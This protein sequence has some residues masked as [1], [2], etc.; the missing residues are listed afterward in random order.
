MLNPNPEVGG[1]NSHKEQN[2]YLLQEPQET[3]GRNPFWQE[4]L[5]Q[6]KRPVSVAAR[7]G[8]ALA[9]LMTGAQLLDKAGVVSADSLLPQV[10][11]ADWVFDNDPLEV[12]PQWLIYNKTNITAAVDLTDAVGRVIGKVAAVDNEE[13]I[14]DPTNAPTTTTIYHS[15]CDAVSEVCQPYEPIMEV[16]NTEKV[17]AMIG[18][19]YQGNEVDVWGERNIG[20]GDTK[21]SRCSLVERLCRDIPWLFGDA[22]LPNNLFRIDGQTYLGNNSRFEGTVGQFLVRSGAN[23]SISIQAVTEAVQGV[24]LPGAK[25]LIVEMGVVSGTIKLMSVASERG[26]DTATINY[27]DATATDINNSLAKEF[28]WA[29]G[30]TKYSDSTGKHFLAVDQ[31]SQSIKGGDIDQD[32]KPTG[33]NYEI[34]YEIFSP[35]GG[36]A[37]LWAGVDNRD[38]VH[39]WFSGRDLI[40]D[41]TNTFIGHFKKGDNPNTDPK[42][43]FRYSLGP[44]DR[45]VYGAYQKE[46]KPKIVKGLPVFEFTVFGT[47][48]TGNFEWNYGGRERFAINPDFSPPANPK[49]SYP[50]NGLEKPLPVTPVTRK[51]I[52]LPILFKQFAGGW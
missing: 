24:N 47:A 7:S 35:G 22:G 39:I 11:S 51:F 20:N 28:W 50:N 9:V 40:N 31:D 21:G 12:S 18:V 32:G 1:G 42:A 16:P 6:I 26:I 8:L 15:V 29:T 38:T 37:A 27:K 3:R 25:S 49:M 46:F 41:S 33:I 19:D 43:L 23:N 5:K 13:P 14:F 34:N 17:G 10:N 4:S 30:L 44:T 52:Y 45:D 2:R 36:I 48:S